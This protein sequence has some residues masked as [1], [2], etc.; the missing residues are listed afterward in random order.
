MLFLTVKWGFW[1]KVRASVTSFK[2]DLLQNLF[3][4][5]Y[6]YLIN[7]IDLGI[8][9]YLY[10]ILD[11]DWKIVAWIIIYISWIVFHHLPVIVVHL[12]MYFTFYWY[13]LDLL[14]YALLWLPRLCSQ[15]E[16][17][18]VKARAGG[19]RA[20]FLRARKKLWYPGYDYAEYDYAEY[21]L[22]W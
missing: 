7:Y 13:A 2:N 14:R 15:E 22:R 4:I 3:Y 8:T 10:C 12:K 17:A 20:F 1:I 5:Q 6:L 19:G 11:W 18:C 9:I 21:G 16:S